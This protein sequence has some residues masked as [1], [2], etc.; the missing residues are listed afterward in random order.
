MLLRSDL[1]LPAS[2]TSIRSAALRG[3][4]YGGRNCATVNATAPDTTATPLSEAWASEGEPRSFE[5]APP[6][7]CRA[8]SSPDVPPLGISHRR[9]DRPTDQSFRPRL[10]VGRSSIFASSRAPIRCAIPRRKRAADRRANLRRPCD[11]PLGVP[12][13]DIPTLGNVPGAHPLAGQRVAPMQ[14]NVQWRYV[15]PFGSVA[16]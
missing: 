11:L 5:T 7:P 13:R 3:V 12:C 1:T 8:S 2:L 15:T 4:E 9:P 16:S 10:A 6:F 14:T